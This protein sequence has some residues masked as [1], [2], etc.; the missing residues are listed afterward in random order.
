MGASGP[1]RAWNV[2]IISRPLYLAVNCSVCLASEHTYADFWEMIPGI[3]SAFYAPCSTV[4]T[5]M[6]SVYEA[7]DRSSHNFYVPVDSWR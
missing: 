1:V 6:A 2:D 7:M 5:R 4:D 3:I